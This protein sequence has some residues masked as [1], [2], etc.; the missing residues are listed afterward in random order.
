LVTPALY[1]LYPPSTQCSHWTTE[2]KKLHP[3]LYIKKYRT[4]SKE[5]TTWF[6]QHIRKSQKNI[7]NKTSNN[8]VSK[9]HSEYIY[10]KTQLWIPDDIIIYKHMTRNTETYIMKIKLKYKNKI[11]S[12]IHV[13]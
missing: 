6:P 11:L 8:I 10:I 12:K 5:E 7:Y 13:L 9:Y 1:N 4:H 2:P 3:Y